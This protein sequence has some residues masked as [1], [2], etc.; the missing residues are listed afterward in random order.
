MS[1]RIT[2][3]P[4]AEVVRRAYGAFASRDFATMSEVLA[5]DARWHSAG[6][7]W[8]VGEYTGREAILG[9]FA[10][11]DSY[12]EGTYA[13]ELHDV[14]ANDDRAVALQRS[15]AERSDGQALSVEAA[16]VF[17]FQDGKVTD[18]RAWPW[19][20]YAEDEFYG[21]EPPPG[22]TPPARAVGAPVAGAP[23]N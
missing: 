7:N 20:L 6:R 12:S 17:E 23:Q 18:V 11:I 15:S 22:Q 13:T 19:D 14:L 5:D 3:H 1:S 9:F 2:E 16:V 4:N 10:A 21:L 8:L